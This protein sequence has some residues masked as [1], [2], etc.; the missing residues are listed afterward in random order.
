M[1][2]PNVHRDT[3]EPERAGY[4]GSVTSPD[5]AE[6]PAVRG[7]GHRH[8]ALPCLRL[9]RAGPIDRSEGDAAAGQEPVPLD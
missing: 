8:V 7:D 6:E 1:D 9:P 3:P 4:R 2:Q 5:E